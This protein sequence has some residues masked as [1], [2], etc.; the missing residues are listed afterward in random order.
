MIR[1]A[2]TLVTIV[3]TSSACS[4]IT[5]MPAAP[6]EIEQTSLAQDPETRA[7]DAVASGAP[8]ILGIQGYSLTFPGVD[9][10]S[11]VRWIGYRILE[12][13]S[14]VVR[15]GPCGDYQGRATT[16]AERFNRTVIRSLGR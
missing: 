7:R 2:V 12:G 8:Y 1:A 3:L 6:C 4:S 16:Y 10:L 13:T 5:S 14:D 15:S 11:V 9:D